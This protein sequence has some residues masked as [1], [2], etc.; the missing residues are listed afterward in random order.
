[1]TLAHSE[2]CTFTACS[3]FCAVRRAKHDAD[4]AAAKRAAIRDVV[5]QLGHHAS[6]YFLEQSGWPRSAVEAAVARGDI[7]WTSTGNLEVT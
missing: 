6:P 4:V 7:R 1:M 5:T 3:T 2:Y